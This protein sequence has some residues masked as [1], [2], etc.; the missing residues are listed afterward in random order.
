[1]STVREMM[2]ELRIGEDMD[3]SGRGLIFCTISV[4]AWMK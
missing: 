3:G 1:M 2:N 4:F